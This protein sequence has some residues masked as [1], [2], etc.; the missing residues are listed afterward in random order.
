MDTEHGFS[1]DESDGSTS[2]EDEDASD[3]SDSGFED[4]LEDAD[5]DS[6]FE[7]AIESPDRRVSTRPQAGNRV[8]APEE[9]C[10]PSKTMEDIQLPPKSSTNKAKATSLPGTQPHSSSQDRLGMGDV[11]TSEETLVG[12]APH[13]SRQELTSERAPAVSSA[14]NPPPVSVT[15]CHSQDRFDEGGMPASER[16]PPQQQGGGGGDLNPI[17]RTPAHSR[18][19][20][21]FN[22]EP[23]LAVAPAARSE[24]SRRGH[25]ERNRSKEDLGTTSAE[26][27][28]TYNAKESTPAHASPSLSTSRSA[29]N[30]VSKYS[31]MNDTNWLKPQTDFLEATHSQPEVGAA[32]APGGYAEFRRKTLSTSAEETPAS[33]S[34][35]MLAVGTAGA[36][37]PS[38]AW[39]NER[40]PS[41]DTE[42]QC[43][44]DIL[45]DGDAKGETG[46]Q[47][48][49]RVQVHILLLWQGFF[50]QRMAAH[51]SFVYPH[52][53]ILIVVF[54]AVD[55]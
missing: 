14:D 5:D 48:V 42:Q 4:A 32:A 7:D 27:T 9:G 52:S 54:C 55:L 47:G 34:A 26:A 41:P 35:A 30:M 45:D 17:F 33:V 29:G 38:A 2:E 1:D 24:G 39:R 18:D 50:Y 19:R 49:R 44:L 20:N 46:A 16:G 11:Q 31:H 13:K 36:A 53:V 51:V 6:G 22:R 12:D 3:P 37:P 15:P 43:R 40:R 21:A 28:R 8:Q 10:V 23:P 25:R